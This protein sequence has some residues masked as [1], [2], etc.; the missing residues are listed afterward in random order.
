MGQRTQMVIEVTKTEHNYKT[1]KDTKKKY[2]GSYHNQWGIGKMQLWDVMRF[3]T[4][5]NGDD[6]DGYKLPERLYK[7]YLMDDKYVFTGAATP[8]NVMNW[9]NTS[10]DN[11]D[12]GILL[13][14][15]MDRYGMIESGELY[16]F[17]D[18]EMEASREYEK[19]PNAE[20]DYSVNRYISLREY[21]LYCPK[22]FNTDFLTAFTALLRFF[23]IKIIEPKE[24]D[25]ES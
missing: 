6:Y 1:G 17:N 4:T 16:I 3:L 15:N 24:S 11:N 2:L 25:N 7:A 20:P 21:V 13:K 23:N 22:Y 8:E 10:Q 18:P 19:N 14:V 12:G 9:I 5:Y